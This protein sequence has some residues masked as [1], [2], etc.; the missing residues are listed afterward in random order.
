MAYQPKIEIPSPLHPGN[1]M[2]YQLY[3]I[4]IYHYWLYYAIACY[5]PKIQIFAEHHPL[6]DV[7]GQW[8]STGCRGLGHRACHAGHQETQGA[9]IWSTKVGDSSSIILPKIK[10][11]YVQNAGS[12]KCIQFYGRFGDNGLQNSKVQC[13]D[14]K[15]AIQIRW[16]TLKPEIQPANIGLHKS[17]I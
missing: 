13:L 17:R 16:Y 10:M 9:G 4:I 12:S 1:A 14:A 15:I 8:S 5:I 3:P 11:Q 7:N 6:E 2:L